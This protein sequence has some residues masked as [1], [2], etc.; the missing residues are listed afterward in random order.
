MQDFRATTF[1]PAKVTNVIASVTVHLLSTVWT[2]HFFFF[3]Q[4]GESLQIAFGFSF[5][6]VFC[7]L[8]DFPPLNDSDYNNDNG[9]HQ[10]DM[11]EPAQRIT[12]H[13]SQQPQDYQYYCNRPQHLMLLSAG[14]VPLSDKRLKERHPPLP[15]HLNPS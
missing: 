4:G 7:R 6:R 11:D 1:M 10:Y 15:N 5:Y 2:F 8:H 13:K 9:N 14:S 3:P 12:A